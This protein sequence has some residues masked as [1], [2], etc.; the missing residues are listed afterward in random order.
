MKQK[1]KGKV[2]YGD[3]LY[4]LKGSY[5]LIFMHHG[6]VYRERIG[7]VKDIPLTMARNIAVKK[8][9][10]IIEGTF[11]PKKEENIT[12]KALA[13]EYLKWYEAHHHNTRESTKAKQKHLINKLI[14]A[15]GDVHAVDITAFRIEHYKQD[16]FKEKASPK[17]INNELTTCVPSSERLKS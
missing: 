7:K 14:K 15:F 5:W 9:A 10:E 11:L 17:T 13:Q 12:F 1:K 4:E 2:S 16:R 3:N 8:K 6:K